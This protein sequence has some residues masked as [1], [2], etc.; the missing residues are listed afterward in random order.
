MAKIV[1]VSVIV[2]VIWAW[3]DV[4]TYSITVHIIF[5]IQMAVVKALR[6][7]RTWTDIAHVG[8]RTKAGVNAPCPIQFGIV[9][10]HLVTLRSSAYQVRVCVVTSI[11]NARINRLAQRVAINIVEMVQWTHVFITALYTA[12][13]LTHIALAIREAKIAETPRTLSVAVTILSSL[14]HAVLI[15]AYPIM[16][17]IVLRVIRTTVIIQTQA[18]TIAIVIRILRTLV[19]RKTHVVS[20]NIVIRIQWATV[21]FTT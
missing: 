13:T 5:R 21:F 10:L 9:A 19:L 1:T 4:P 15:P 14:I 16:I 6:Y 18:V 12:C 11:E 2:P 7:A 3:I 8:R 17:Y 20:I